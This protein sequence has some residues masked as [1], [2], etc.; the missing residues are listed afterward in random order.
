[1]ESKPVRIEI[2]YTDGCPNRSTTVKRVWDVLEELAVAGEL[3]EV[4]VHPP[5]ASVRGFLGTPTVHVNG[6]DIEPSAQ[7]S[8]WSGVI[9]RAY[10]DGEQIDGAPSKR[11]IRQAILDA[12]NTLKKTAKP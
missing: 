10:R 11:L 8:N 7:T 1:M 5:L 12:G 2:Y 3:R 9:C 4:R 6:I